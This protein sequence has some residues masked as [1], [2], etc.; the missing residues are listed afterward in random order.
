M[1][2]FP[3]SPRLLK[4]GLVVVDP[5]TGAIQR[6][7]ALQY[8]PDMLSRSLQP[9]SV[10]AESADRSSALRLKGPP[11]E[12]IKLEAEIDAADMLERGDPTV[13]EVGILASLAVIESLVSP[14]S[15]QLTELNRLAASG[16]LAI[17][18]MVAPLTLF[19]WSRHR[20]TPVRITDLSITEEAFDPNLNPIRAKLG[21]GLRVLSVD[22]L[23]FD[24]KGGNVFLAYLRNKEQLA[25]RD[26]AGAL[27]ALGLTGLP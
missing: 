24:T 19:V 17:A 12:T 13:A 21:L 2:T 5:E 9:K 16:T 8:N 23:G 11:V 3:N 14:T 18:P 26:R 25:Q 20:V 10:G 7:V 22:D 1:T 4:G 6:I 15:A 27:S